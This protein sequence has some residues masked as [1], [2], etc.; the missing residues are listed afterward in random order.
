MI[1]IDVVTDEEGKDL[2]R[3]TKSENS[4]QFLLGTSTAGK[5]QNQTWL[6]LLIDPLC[7]TES[8]WINMEAI[9]CFTQTRPGQ[10]VDKFYK[11]TVEEE[12]FRSLTNEEIPQ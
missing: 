9:R 2:W 7:S 10:D 3:S 5:K 11:Q 1:L 6:V 4:I 12:L 8:Q